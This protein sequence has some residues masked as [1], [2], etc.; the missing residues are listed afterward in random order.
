MVREA[1]SRH[2]RRRRPRLRL[3]GAPD[4]RGRLAA[5]RCRTWS[6]TS[7]YDRD[8]DPDKAR[9]FTWQGSTR[10]LDDYIDLLVDLSG[11]MMQRLRAIKAILD[12]RRRQEEQAR[13]V[14]PSR[15]GQV[16]FL[17]GRPHAAD[18][19]EQACDAPAGR[20]LLSCVP[21]RAG[22]DR[23]PM[24]VCDAGVSDAARDER[25][26]AAARDGGR[27]GDRHRHRRDRAA[28]PPSRARA[29]RAVPALRRAQ[30]GGRAAATP[31]RLKNTTKPAHR[32]DRHDRRRLADAGPVLADRSQ[33]ADGAVA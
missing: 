10:D 13:N 19:W 8:K 12:E 6:A 7:C 22:A 16:L 28:L 1:P 30:Y 23:A 25:R 18:A 17:H 26:P 5:G 27:S 31:R 20:G 15:D 4:R 21:D 14:S 24:A 11:D 32:L 2:A 3:P 33:R 29:S 9:P